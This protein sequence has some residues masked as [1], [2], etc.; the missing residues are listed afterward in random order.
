MFGIA[1]EMPVRH[2]TELELKSLLNFY[3]PADAHRV[4]DPDCVL[5]PCLCLDLDPTVLGIW[6]VN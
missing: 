2:F 6:E 1:P 3:L 4:G 5:G